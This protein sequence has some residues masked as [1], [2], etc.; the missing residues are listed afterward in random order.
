M[1]GFHG[2]LLDMA[3]K[4]ASWTHFSKTHNVCLL[5]EQPELLE[6]QRLDIL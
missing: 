3:G 1:Q 6:T 2:D 4:G 5:T